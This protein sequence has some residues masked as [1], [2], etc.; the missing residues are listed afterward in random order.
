MK[1]YQ[2]ILFDWDGTAVESRKAPTDRVIPHMAALLEQGVVLVIVSG[3]TYGNIDGGRL[4]TRFPAELL[5]RLYLGLGRGALNYG[6]VAGR[7]VV[8]EERKLSKDEKLRLDE[9]C[10]RFHQHMLAHYDYDTD[11]VFTRPQYCKIDLMPATDRGDQLYLQDGELR[12][13]TASLKEHGFEGG[14]PGLISLAEQLGQGFAHPIKVTADAK[15]LEV[16]ISTKSDNVDF[17]A[18][19]ILQARGIEIERCAFVGDEFASLTDGIP[20]SD[21]YMMTDSTA[22]GDF[23][24]VSARPF[25]LPESVTHLG[26]GIETFLNFLKEQAGSAGH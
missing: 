17:F 18:N 22:G 1:K 25:A 7:P 26:G 23:Y 6:F 10:F 11:I 15:Y 3:T 21:A 8:L 4:H 9:I 14:I 13:L 5:N 12:Q 2:A 19:R 16:G 24:D 20:G